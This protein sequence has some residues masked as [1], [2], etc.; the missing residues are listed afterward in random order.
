MSVCSG[1]RK[2]FLTSCCVTVLPLA[3]VLLVAEHVVDR[4]AD[5]ADRIDA[6]MIVEAAILDRQDRLHHH[7]GMT[8]SGTSRRFSRASVTSAVISGVSSVIFSIGFLAP[9]DLEVIDRR[10][11]GRFAALCREHDPDELPSPVAGPRNH[12]NGV[13]AD[14][15]FPGLFDGGSIRITQIVQAI[16]RF[17]SGLNDCPRRNSY[18]RAKTRGSDRTVSPDNRASIMPGKCQI[19]VDGDNREDGERHAAAQD[20]VEF[21][22]ATLET[23]A[24]T[25]TRSRRHSG[26]RWGQSHMSRGWG[27]DSILPSSEVRY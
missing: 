18:G 22:T 24:R 17:G 6:G 12:Q 27:S 4:G 13:A 10:W 25:H 21:P 5:D 9:D 15:E 8:A 1:V 14:G 20:C 11:F 16:R 7:G 19:E 3:Q 26:A 23:A 2:V